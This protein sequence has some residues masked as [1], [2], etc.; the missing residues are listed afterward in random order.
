MRTIIS[1]GKPSDFYCHVHTFIIG[2][3][4]SMLWFYWYKNY[5]AGQKLH[6]VIVIGGQIKEMT[7]YMITDIVLNWTFLSPRQNSEDNCFKQETKDPK[8]PGGAQSQKEA[9]TKTWLE[10]QVQTKTVHCL[11]NI[12]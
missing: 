3:I 6:T 9:R 2:L 1:V 8:S 11:I 10:K 7:T 12:I 5:N 4:G